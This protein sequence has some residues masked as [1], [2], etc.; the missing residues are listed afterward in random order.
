MESRLA[1]LFGRP[2]SQSRPESSGFRV[3]RP[4]VAIYAKVWL[5][6]VDTPVLA[7]MPV[8]VATE[9]VSVAFLPNA[10]RHTAALDFVAPY[11]YQLSLL[12]FMAHSLSYSQQI[13]K[14][15]L[16]QYILILCA[17]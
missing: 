10:G 16:V 11:N 3:E 15:E 5:V 12:Y 13:L 2:H 4:P 1:Q 17:L 7:V 6:D 9:Q 14:Q 8:P